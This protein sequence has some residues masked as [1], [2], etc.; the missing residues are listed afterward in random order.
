[1]RRRRSER[2]AG[3]AAPKQP[4]MKAAYQPDETAP[5]P[6]GSETRAVPPQHMPQR[7]PVRASYDQDSYAAPAPRRFDD[8]DYED[9]DYDAPRLWPKLLA[10]VLGLALILSAGIYFLVPE[11][12]DGILGT[13]RGALGS[14]VEG[15]KGLVGLAEDKKPTLIKFETPDAVGQLDVRTVFTFTADM[16]VDSVRMMDEV[17]NEVIGQLAKIDPQGTVWTLSVV[18]DE[19]FNGV[20]RGDMLVKDTWY[21]GDKQIRFMTAEATPAPEMEDLFTP[22]EEPELSPVGD[23]SASFAAMLPEDG[24]EDTAA[25]SEV[26]DDLPEDVFVVGDPVDTFADDDAGLEESAD[27]TPN[28][29]DAGTTGLTAQEPAQNAEPFVVLRTTPDTQP[30]QT[31]QE[32]E[33]VVLDEW[34]EPADDSL[35]AADNTVTEDI[36][37]DDEPSVEEG[38]AADN[39]NENASGQSEWDE[40][41]PEDQPAQTVSAAETDETATMPKLAMEP[42]ESALPSKLK[43]KDDVYEKAKKVKALER[44]LSLDLPGPGSYVS[45][46]GGVFTFRGD[47]FR[48]NASFGTADMPLQQLSVLWKAPL[49]SLRTGEGTLYGL[50]WTGQPAIVK[51]SV[52]LRQMM[53]IT[54]AKKDVKALKEVIVAGQDGKIYFFDLGD[55]VATREPIDVKYPLKGS[56]S[57]DTQGRPMLAVGQG[58]SKLPG[59]TGPIGL[60]LYEL[61]GQ[62]EL[63]FLNGRKTNKQSQ[64]STNGAFDGTALFDRNTDTMIVAGENGLLYTVALNTVF[65]YIDQQVI[66]VNPVITYLKSK[67]GTQQDMSVSNEASVAM[68]G[69]YAFMADRQ[70]IIKAVDTDSMLTQ[71]AFDAGDN[72]DATPALGFDEDGSLGLYTGTTVYTRSKKAAAATIRRLDALTGREVWKN[73]IP[74][75][76]SDDERAGV[77]ASPV[78]GE[79]GLDDL[80][81][82]TVNRTNEGNDATVYAFN[83]QTGSEVWSF[84]LGSPTVSS[85][86]AV[87]TSSGEGYIV[88][89]DEKG[90]LY[91]LNGQTGDQL[92]TLEL[93]ASIDASPA[94]YND[95]LVIGSNDKDNCYLYGIRLE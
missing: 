56:V 3:A 51:W 5:L 84:Q 72:T 65:D 13:V 85:P 43:I 77:K 24:L 67:S 22:T 40:I 79:K 55:G 71:W 38:D 66:K 94:V 69:K 50:G 16:P 92:H 83:K 39:A 82:F 76:Y 29:P 27:Q 57:L 17:G 74:A 59:K 7:A 45:Y 1:M 93:G 47:A 73:E 41:S 95:V 8:D 14:A 34:D 53:N 35:L 6:L 28:G 63:M 32:Q 46:E 64:Y 9:D 25:F 90:V 68:Y 30:I 58:V 89:A 36:V 78:I 44:G 86:V 11:N 10:L 61:I 48:G 31:A 62:K 4:E 33:P 42:D 21:P 26:P 49:G 60:Y 20:F 91:L 52:E 75:K 23:A 2:H 81:I 15:A 88:Q 87:Y 37:P 54:E 19:P 80:V 70:G 12:S 18:F